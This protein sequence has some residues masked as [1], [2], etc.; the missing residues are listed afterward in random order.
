ME[1]RVYPRVIKQFS[2]VVENKEG[3]KLNVVAVDASSEGVCIQCNTFERNLITPGGCFVSNGKPIELFV[4]LELPGEGGVLQKIG[5]RCHVAFSRRISRD[6]CKI[7]MRYME[8]EDGVYDTL[9][10]CI[11]SATA[12]NDC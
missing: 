7:G 10:H 5:A 1:K 6:Q 2:A 12:S 9:I 3:V 11:E 4:M 8:L